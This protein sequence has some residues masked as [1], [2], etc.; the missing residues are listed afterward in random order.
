[1]LE[2]IVGK[3]WTANSDAIMQMI[4]RDVRAGKGNRILLVPELVSHDTERMLCQIAGDTASR[5]AEVLSFSRLA[6]RVAT[7]TGNAPVPCMDNAGRLVVM[8]AA[9]RQ[10]HGSLKVFAVTYNTRMSGFNAQTSLPIAVAK[11]VLPTPLPPNKNKGLKIVLPG[12][13]AISIAAARANLFGSPLIKLSNVYCALSWLSQ[14]SAT[15]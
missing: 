12:F 14:A 5:F 9:A 8:A 2:I 4:S 15:S 11:C 1:M 10:L 13:L 6:R 7:Y 3:D